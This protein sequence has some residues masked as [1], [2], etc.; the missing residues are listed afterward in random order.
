MNSITTEKIVNRARIIL[1]VFVLLLAISTLRAKSEP[2]VTYSIF[3]SSFVYFM[4]A[5]INYLYYRR[6]V[7]SLKL[8]YLSTTIETCL[9]FFVKYSFHWDPHNGYG[10][11]VKEP[12]TF[13]VYMIFAVLCGLRYNK[14]LIAYY[15][16]LSSVSIVLLVVLGV[17]FGGMTFSDDPKLAF[18]PLSLRFPT[19]MGK[20][21]FHLAICYFVYLMAD[22]T[23]KNMGI[24]E[25]SRNESERNLGTVN[26]L[27][28]TVKKTAEELTKSS[29]DLSQSTSIIGG[30]ITEN[31]RYISEISEMANHFNTSIQAL[32]EKI[33]SQKSSIDQNFRR[34]NE[35]SELME[36]VYTVS[37]SQTEKSTRALRIA[38]LNEGYIKENFSSIGMMQENSQ[39][40]ED[41]SKTINSI[42]D[43]TGLLALNA[44]IESARAG[45]YGKGFAVVA[46]E[47]S[48][49]ATISIDSSKEISS[50]IKNTVDNINHVSRTFTDMAAG[51]DKIT[52]FVK[53]NSDFIKD[54]NIKTEK[55]F[56][57]S[58]LL[59][60]STVEIDTTTREVIDHFK[61]QHELN[62]KIYDWMNNMT[63]LSQNISGV[64]NDLVLLSGRLKSG[65]EEMNKILVNA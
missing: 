43:Q 25:E 24:I 39:K 48:K 61:S 51:L 23:N 53:E 37:S 13:I 49:L 47:I 57:E 30:I 65:S 10:M 7:V 52:S 9:I 8:I 16:I 21:V 4:L 1:A 40:I 17:A 35:I 62:G 14:K 64:L 54:L 58:K 42:A 29:N 45:D 59:Q 20:L 18:D 15:T 19:E 63:G 34:I 55:E 28:G 50:I 6:K 12:A 46:D 44:A 27:L 5:L 36:A 56:R 2:S 11:S 60:S 38:E 26:T 41:I 33:T 32:N 31:N 3:F 22:Y